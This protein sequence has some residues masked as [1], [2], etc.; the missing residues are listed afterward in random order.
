MR[1]SFKSLRFLLFIALISSLFLA[2]K[3]PIKIGISKSAGS[4]GYEQYAKWIESLDS[5]VEAIDLYHLD[6]KEAEAIIKECSGLII[7]G[8]P[9][10]APS[11]YGKG[12]D[13]VRCEIDYRRDTLEFSL[14]K[15]AKQMKLPILAIC[16]GE[17]IL[18]VAYGGSLIVDIPEDFGKDIVHRCKDVVNCKHSVQVL[19]GS[20]LN[21]LSGVTNDIVNSNH[22]QAVEHLADDFKVT[23]MSQDGLIE[24]YEWKEAEGKP[25]LIAVQWH[26]ERL[27]ENNPLS[28]PIGNG[29]LKAIKQYYKQKNGLSARK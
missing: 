22:H 9:D 12:Y 14:I 5:D 2:C 10:V 29:F 4:E 11:N 15:I 1:I 24:A 20:L 25:F 19:P 21:R 17:Q 16:R 3:E 8:G 26:P 23:A 7:S 28:K 18:N 13:S 27:A 6:L